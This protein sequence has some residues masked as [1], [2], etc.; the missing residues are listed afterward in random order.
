MPQQAT[1]KSKRQ[2]DR[3]IVSGAGQSSHKLGVTAKS[4]IALT[5]T[6]IC[7]VAVLTWKNPSNAES[8]TTNNQQIPAPSETQSTKAN[9]N[10]QQAPIMLANREEMHQ[11]LVSQLEEVDQ[12]L[13]SYREVSKY[14]LTSRPISEHPDQIYPNRA[15]T[16]D[17][18]MRLGNGRTDNTIQISSSQSRV[19]L[20]ANESVSFTVQAKDANQQPLPLLVTRAI[21]QSI[22]FSN[23]RPGTQVPLGFADNGRDGD[24]LANDGISSGVF[25]PANS[26]LSSFHG[27]I[28]TE[29]YYSVNGKA[30]FLFFDVIY[31]PELPANWIG[32][33]REVVENGSLV[34]YLPIDVRQAGRYIVNA[35]VDDAKGQAFA[36][37]NFND[38]LPQGRGE[39]RLSVA[40]NLI[41][42]QQTSFP[43]SLRDVD[44]Y[45][46]KEDVDPDRALI[47]RR[48]AV[49]HQTKKYALTNFSEAEPDTEERRRH[50]NEFKKD[51]ELAKAALVAF[52]PEQ[53]GRAFPQSA[54]SLKRNSLA[55]K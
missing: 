12:T 22:D 16:E 6:L 41:R 15:V 35:R 2:S 37:L 17:H 4:L 3:K 11:K 42:D 18:P 34:F 5:F 13:C 53:A 9:L 54:C 38:L 32:N 1:S 28:R 25:H 19:Y 49:V 8:T 48:E 52:D 46:L 50:L 14:P 29:I 44:G 33:I 39:I 47:P 31:S 36:L 30:G 20:A 27:T 21:S 24:A 45:L 55:A 7:V 40:G 23:Q 51:V 26:S 43:L 10:K